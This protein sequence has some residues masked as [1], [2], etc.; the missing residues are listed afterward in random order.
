MTA[1]AINKRNV[2]LVYLL[3]NKTV[4]GRLSRN[5]NPVLKYVYGC[6]QLVSWTNGQTGRQAD[7]LM[8]KLPSQP[9]SV[10]VTN[11]VGQCGGVTIVTVE[12]VSNAWCFNLIL[13]ISI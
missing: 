4:Q 3:V 2:I 9:F 10:K 11:T 8:H 5:G 12:S 13:V 6:H 1:L 7:K